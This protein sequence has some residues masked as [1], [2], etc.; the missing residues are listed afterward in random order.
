MRLVIYKGPLRTPLAIFNEKVLCG[1]GRRMDNQDMLL[2]D[3][4]EEALAVLRRFAAVLEHAGNPDLTV[5]ATA[6]IREAQ[7]GPDLVAQI[8][9]LGF[10][11]VVLSGEEEARIGAFGIL[12]GSP[13]VVEECDPERPHLCG[14]MGGGSLELTRFTNSINDPL[15]ERV[16]LPLGPLRLIAAHGPKVADAAEA[17]RACLEQHEWLAKPKTTALFAVGGA[18]RAIAKVHMA[19]HDY[20]LPI[21][22]HYEISRAGALDV[23]ELLERQSAASLL[24]MPGVQT[25]RIE[26]LP[27]AAMVLRQVVQY[28]RARQIVISSSGV[29]EGVLFEELPRKV[30][31]RDPFLEL[32]AEYARLYCPDQAFGPEV[33]RLTHGLIADE[34]PY[35]RRIRQAACLMADIAAYHHPDMRAAHASDMVLRS[36]FTGIDHKGRVTLSAALY[37]RHFGKP[38]M[39]PGEIVEELLDE[40]LTHVAQVTGLA[41]RFAADFSPKVQS[42]LAG[43]SFSLEKGKLLF[44]GPATHASLMGEVPQKRLAALAGLLEVEPV[45]EFSGIS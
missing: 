2:P 5:F 28:T 32:A 3:A 23:C 33:F 22:H 27:H 43:C 24:S 13:S 44:Q 21:L 20:P 16:S 9:E 8:R 25:K 10:D 19:M 29:R 17:V 6:A 4:M 30:R 18:W 14:D 36:P 26:T 38:A 40:R 12:A 7:N 39:M 37:Q 1:L 41:L 11:P 34:T 15:A 31:R 45:V 35:E 42:G